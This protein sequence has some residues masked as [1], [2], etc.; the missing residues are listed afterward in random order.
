MRG[1]KPDK[2]T[3]ELLGTE[4][5]ECAEFISN[6]NSTTNNDEDNP[7]PM[8]TT[9]LHAESPQLAKPQQMRL[10][11][12]AL[13]RT[14]DRYGL[15]DRAAAAVASAVLQDLSVVIPDDS[16]HVIDR[17]KLRRERAK[18]RKYGI[19]RNS[20]VLVGLFLDGRKDKTVV[21]QKRGGKFYKI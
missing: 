9:S 18:K 6:E 14:S 16:S 13:A 4:T 3:E 10:P 15:S 5:T 12:P 7:R 1:I 2:M 19:E 11:L 8:A 20:V 21:N 17:S